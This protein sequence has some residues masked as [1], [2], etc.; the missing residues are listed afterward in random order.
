MNKLNKTLT[1]LIAL[2]GLILLLTACPGTD[3][4][5]PP[6][7][8]REV[9]I[10]ETTKVPDQATRDALTVYN[11]DTGEMRFNASTPILDNLKVGDAFV[12]EPSTAAPYG[13]LRKVT[14][15]RKDGGEVML[16][17]S[18]AKLTDAISQ[19]TII[20]EGKVTD[21]QLQ[22]AIPFVEGVNVTVSPSADEL[23]PQVR[24]ADG[25]GFNIN[26]AVDSTLEIEGK[27]EAGELGLTLN[28]KG[29][30]KFDVGYRFVVDISP[31]EVAGIPLPVP[32]L[33]YLEASMNYNENVSFTIK[34]GA[35][36][37][38]E[39][40]VQVAR[41]PFAPI[42]VFIGIP[43]VIVPSAAITIGVD[44]KAELQFDY[45]YSQTATYTQGVSWQE[46]NGWKRIDRNEFN[47]KHDG[48]NY[49]GKAELRTYVRT[50]M[51]V[52][53][54]DA[55]GLDVGATVGAKLDVAYPRDPVWQ[56]SGFVSGDTGFVLDIFGEEERFSEEIFNVEKVI[57]SGSP[58]S[59]TIT[60]LNPNPSVDL[61]AEVDLN[62]YVKVEDKYGVSVR[63]ASD[64]E[65]N[66][67]RFTV[68][69]FQTI[70]VTA[71]NRFGKT[72][73]AFFT[74]NVVNTP[75]DLAKLTN[76]TNLTVGQGDE[77]DLNFLGLPFDKNTG[78]LKCNA[79]RWSVEGAD[80]IRK[81]QGSCNA[82]AIFAEQGTRKAKVTVTDP[83]GLASERTFDINVTTAP[84][85]LVPVSDI[86]VLNNGAA[87][88]EQ[89]EVR[90]D[91]P[92]LTASVTVDNPSGATVSYRWSFVNTQD[93]L[94][95]P[96][97]TFDNLS[98]QPQLTLRPGQQIGSGYICGRLEPGK[99]TP[100]P[101]YG[102][103]RLSVTI[104]GRAA[105]KVRDF[106]IR[107]VGS[108]P[109]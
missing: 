41:I 18:Q 65:N 4:P 84:S 70:T 59:P 106:K 85:F 44:G 81:T 93:D 66:S 9:I 71:T 19:G 7:V 13:Y 109:S 48:P 24:F 57:A 73:Q 12:G 99:A 40:E 50:T 86:Q 52:L 45:T 38:F 31:V 46:D 61:L 43:I 28:F 26:Q 75:P 29:Q 33:N 77:L 10:P 14:A 22:S 54:Y 2:A 107:C 98:S 105:P 27:S 100:T 32:D 23:D 68:P 42:V 51:R 101:T 3:P 60:I 49:D 88:E 108:A 90:L 55:G 76:E 72:A 95:T 102:Y 83:E 63:F 36:G 62:Q 67:S 30:V 103:F 87:I 92:S 5:T 39:K 34:G 15:I 37:K 11:P 1:R 104:E 6:L 80:T 25:N 69:G 56:L 16:E 21:L 78:V 89:A 47:V 20:M 53:L 74:L 8:E 35:Y 79:I 64:K 94:V 17:T 97:Q 96:L 58:P 82:V 91:S